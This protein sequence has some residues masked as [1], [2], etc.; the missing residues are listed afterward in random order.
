MSSLRLARLTSQNP[1]IL[2]MMDE[3]LGLALGLAD[4]KGNLDAPYLV[5]HPPRMLEKRHNE[6]PSSDKIYLLQSG[7]TNHL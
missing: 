4:Q 2:K 1:Q 3:M 7:L 6:L 5:F